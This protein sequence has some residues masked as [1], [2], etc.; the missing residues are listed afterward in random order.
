MNKRLYITGFILIFAAIACGGLTGIFLF[1]IRD[2]PQIRSLETYTPSA[3]TRIYSADNQLLAELYRKKRDPVSL[4]KIPNYL[5][6]AIITAEDPTVLR[7]R[8]Y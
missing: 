5:K 6:Q 3:I 4:D 7:T 1:M 8:R 2:L